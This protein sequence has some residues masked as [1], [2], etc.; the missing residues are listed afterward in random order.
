M[1][2]VEELQYSYAS[3]GNPNCLGFFDYADTDDWSD[4][5]PSGKDCQ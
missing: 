3:S 5:I 1:Y 4:P 2:I